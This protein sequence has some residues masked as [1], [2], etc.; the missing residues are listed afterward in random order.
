MCA[1]AMSAGNDKF[2]AGWKEGVWLGVPVESGESLTGTGEGVVKARDL[3]RKAEN[4][5]RWAVTDFDKFAGVPWEPYPG[6]KG[7]FEL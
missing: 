6:A 4:G 7:G 5:G 1:P 3:R 2:D